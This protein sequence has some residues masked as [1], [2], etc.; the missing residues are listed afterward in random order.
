MYI[1]KRVACGLHACYM[2]AWDCIGYTGKY[3]HLMVMY[4]IYNTL[5]LL[6]IHILHP[7]YSNN[8]KFAWCIYRLHI[9]WFTIIVLWAHYAV[10]ECT[11]C[12]HGI[13]VALYINDPHILCYYMD[14]YQFIISPNYLVV[15]WWIKAMLFYSTYS[16][17]AGLNIHHYTIFFP[18]VVSMLFR[19]TKS[20]CHHH[21]ST[22]IFLKYYVLTCHIYSYYLLQ[23][24]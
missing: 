22:S 18:T 20:F 7:A 6:C 19:C 24:Q 13:N 16:Q 3:I 2:H 8:Y 5:I 21:I 15:K 11:E 23:F 14:A 10:F 12:R 9:I 4:N 1:Y 17:L